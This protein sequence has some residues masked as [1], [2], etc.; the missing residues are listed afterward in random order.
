MC[1][2]WDMDNPFCGYARF[3][4]FTHEIGFT[5]NSLIQV[6]KMSGFN[7]VSIYPYESKNKRL[8]YEIQK[9]IRKIVWRI[10]SLGFSFPPEKNKYRIIHARRIFAVAKKTS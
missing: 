6:L 10:I 4:D 8:R 5:G 2:M 9:I 3:S 7:E 1:G